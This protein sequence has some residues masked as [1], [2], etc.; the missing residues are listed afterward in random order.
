MLITT[1]LGTSFSG[2]L[3]AWSALKFSL[4]SLALICFIKIGLSGIS[5]SEG[6]IVLGDWL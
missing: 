5:S 1:V 6:E 4:L 2:S 3:S